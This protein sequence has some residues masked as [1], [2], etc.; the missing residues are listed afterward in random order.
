LSKGKNKNK[1]LNIYATEINNQR[2]LI[3]KKN[4]KTETKSKRKQPIESS[5]DSTSEEDD[6]Q[7]LHIVE[8]PIEPEVRFKKKPSA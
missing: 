4:K 7:D 6:G 1:V 2:A 3:K 5:E 8:R